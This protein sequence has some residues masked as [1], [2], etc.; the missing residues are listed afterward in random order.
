MTTY[1]TDRDGQEHLEYHGSTAIE[2]IRKQYGKVR[3]EWLHFN[4][5][6]EAADFYNDHCASCEVA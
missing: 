4:S 6:R 2:R 5:V 3:R 1:T